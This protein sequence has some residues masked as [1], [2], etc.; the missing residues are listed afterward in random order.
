MLYAALTFWLLVI[1]LTAWG[2]HHLWGGMIKPKV[3]NAMLLPGTLVAQIGHVLG[4]LIT[5]GT[6]SNTTLFGQGESG[7][8]ETTPNPES[9]IPIIGPVIVGMLPLLACAT[10]IYFNA[11]ELGQGMLT[12]LGTQPVGPVLPQTIAGF[13]QSLRDLISLAESMAAATRSADY[14]VWQTWVFLYLLICLSIR[15]A[16]FPGYLRGS[17]GAIVVLGCGAALIAS[18]FDVKDPRLVEAWAVLN[19]TV[20]TLLLL[21]MLSLLVRGAVGLVRVLK[22]E[23]Q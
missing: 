18:L 11:R 12:S 23:T 10:A 22:S 20:A 16:P 6:V 8:P 7:A 17:L 13:W 2:V 4:L 14:S 3:F 19:L 9:R 21:L 1:V 15:I 5:G